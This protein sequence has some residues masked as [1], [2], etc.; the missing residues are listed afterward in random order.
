VSPK[1]LYIIHSGYY[2]IISFSDSLRVLL[3][4]K[5]ATKLQDL[6]L[7]SQRDKQ[8][9][10]NSLRLQ[11]EGR[12]SVE[13]GTNNVYEDV[14]RNAWIVGMVFVTQAVLISFVV[15]DIYQDETQTVLDGTGDVPLLSTLGSW[16]FYLVGIFMQCV[17][18]LGPKTNFGTSEQNPHFWVQLLLASKTTGVRCQWHD[19][20]SGDVRERQLWPYDFR[21]WLRFAMSFLINGVGFHILIH[22]LPVQV[23]GQ[24]SLTGVVFRSVGLVYIVDLGTCV[25]L[26]TVDSIVGLLLLY[27]FVFFWVSHNQLSLTLLLLV[28]DAPGTTLTL[29]ESHP[30]DLAK[31]KTNE[32]GASSENGGGKEL[33]ETEYADELAVTQSAETPDKTPAELIERA[34]LQADLLQTQLQKDLDAM[35]AKAEAAQAKPSTV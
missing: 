4:L 26:T 34:R 3:S 20:A 33:S 30:E 31:A 19:E 9:L 8:F 35:A 7:V 5:E 11:A 16:L 6:V 21:L 28:D 15:Y 12:S 23:A 25:K 2:A 17:Y 13:L 32:T 24:S 14:S 1:T 10:L 27:S 18:L 29:S 22:A